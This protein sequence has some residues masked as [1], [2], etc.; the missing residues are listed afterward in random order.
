MLAVFGTVD[1][2]IAKREKPKL[3]SLA[4]YPRHGGNRMSGAK[5]RQIPGRYEPFGGNPASLST[6]ERVAGPDHITRGTI[7]RPG[8]VIDR[9]WLM[10][11]TTGFGAELPCHWPGSRRATRFYKCNA[12][13]HENASP[14]CHDLA[15]FTYGLL[16]R[17][18]L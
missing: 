6:H 2:P 7:S 5:H 4:P 18:I 14:V 16:A 3:K 17:I 12:D 9:K 8:S 10:L 1:S 11:G 15:R 13:I